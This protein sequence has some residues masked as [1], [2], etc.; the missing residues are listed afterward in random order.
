MKA[1][2]KWAASGLLMQTVFTQG[3]LRRKE[4]REECEKELRSAARPEFNRNSEVSV[5]R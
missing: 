4:S 5:I 3:V 2:L 1:Q